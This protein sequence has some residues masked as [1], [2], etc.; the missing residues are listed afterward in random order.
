MI[1]GLVDRIVEAHRTPEVNKLKAEHSGPLTD[2]ILPPVLA[3]FLEVI[4]TPARGATEAR[5]TEL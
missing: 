2:L 1:R 3:V 5:L 4:N